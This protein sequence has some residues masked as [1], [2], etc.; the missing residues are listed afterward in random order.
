MPNV[1]DPFST[2]TSCLAL[3]PAN[4]N[5]LFGVNE[6]VVIVEDL[7]LAE[8]VDALFPRDRPATLAVQPVYLPSVLNESVLQIIQPMNPIET[9]EQILQ[10]I[11]K[12]YSKNVLS[13]K[14]LEELLE[15]V[16]KASKG[17]L[18]VPKTA[19]L[20]RKMFG[21]ELRTS[22]SFTTACCNRIIFDFKS[23]KVEE[24]P[25][26][27]PKEKREKKSKEI[28]CPADGC[29]AEYDIKTIISGE[30]YSFRW[31][32]IWFCIWNQILDYLLY[33]FLSY[34]HHHE[35]QS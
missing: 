32:L 3:S 14:G 33:L 15:L 6:P 30:D 11:L 23:K 35:V 28:E 8:E 4:V 27:K 29:S 9:E 16:V 1:Y 10:R 5:G 25:K 31:V 18:A 13:V 20:F 26:E 24:K 12:F 19:Y 34:S 2:Q 22:Y 21:S 7:H 17:N